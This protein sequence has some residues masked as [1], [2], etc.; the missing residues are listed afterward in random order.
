MKVDIKELLNFF[1]DK[2][3]SQKGDANALMSIL[4]EDL[5]ASVYKHF[6]KGKVEIL[7]ESVLSGTKKGKRLD[8]W[9]VDKENEKL[10]Q[11][12]IKNW[13]ATAIGGKKLSLDA[14][15]SKTKEVSNHYWRHQLSNDLSSKVKHPSKVSKVLL[16]MCKPEKYKTLKVEPLLIYWMPIS[17]DQGGLEPLSVVLVQSLN[18]PLETIF[19]KLYIFSVSL[20]LRQLRMKGEET[21]ELDMPHFEHRMEI[22]TRIQNRK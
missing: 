13:A 4:G 22:L 5:N 16:T 6:R 3:D 12:E 11:C 21:V 14:N 2:K 19:S 17:S 9:I 10:Y 1:D 18:L 8:R 20:Y 7:D 15:D